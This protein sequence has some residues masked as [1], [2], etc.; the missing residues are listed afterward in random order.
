MAGGGGV[1]QR[2]VEMG[3]CGERRVGRDRDREERRD[4][5]VEMGD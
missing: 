2:Q 3:N 1:R 4:N 5:E